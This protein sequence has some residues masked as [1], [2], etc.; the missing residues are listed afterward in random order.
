MLYNEKFNSCI[1]DN[2][3]LNISSIR[4]SPLVFH[5]F[6]LTYSVQNILHLCFSLP[7]TT[8]IEQFFYSV[9][10]IFNMVFSYSGLRYCLLFFVP[11]TTY[12]IQFPRIFHGFT[13]PV[14]HGFTYPVQ[15]ALCIFLIPYKMLYAFSL[16]RTKCFMR[17][18]YS[19]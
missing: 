14:F 1:K 16:L 11:C 9:Q 6:V 3:I 8:Y 4:P 5:S 17:F 15:N 2:N 18:S 10:R 7:R 12:I 19:V 13:Y